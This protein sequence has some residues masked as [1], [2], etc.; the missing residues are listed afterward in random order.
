M[1]LDQMLQMKE[2]SI[3]NFL[4]KFIILLCCIFFL[5]LN[6][7]LNWLNSPRYKKNVLK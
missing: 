6:K 2:N 5:E 3:I 7:C 4:S 1:L